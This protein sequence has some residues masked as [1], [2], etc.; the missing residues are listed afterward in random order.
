MIRGGYEGIFKVPDSEYDILAV[1]YQLPGIHFTVRSKATLPFYLGICDE[2][3]EENTRF[4]EASIGYRNPLA[5]IS[6][7]E[8]NHF[9]LGSKLGI[10]T[11]QNGRILVPK[12]VYTYF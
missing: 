4:L 11:D 10:A 9:F 8:R 6:G 7:G 5:E 1:P 12:S 2:W 3:D